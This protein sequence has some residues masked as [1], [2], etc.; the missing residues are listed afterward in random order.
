MSFCVLQT[1]I[2]F[3]AIVSSC[4]LHVCFFFLHFL[5]KIRHTI[6]IT[7]RRIAGICLHICSHYTIATR[8]RRT[9]WGL[10]RPN[11]KRRTRRM[12]NRILSSKCIFDGI[13]QSWLS[14]CVDL[15]NGWANLV[16][17]LPLYI[18]F[19]SLSCFYNCPCRVI[20]VYILCFFT[21]NLLDI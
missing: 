3:N 11:G 13:L 10:C 14:V 18:C 8:T 2:H 19:V 12:G 21:S 20:N 1:Q 16:F 7:R 4:Y 5:Q 15:L 6:S 17:F 9:P